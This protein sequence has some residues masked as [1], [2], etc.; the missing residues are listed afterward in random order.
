[1]PSLSMSLE[2]RSKFALMSSENLVG[3]KRSFG[4]IL[5]VI[6]CQHD[7]KKASRESHAKIK[8]MVI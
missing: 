6:L 5:A 8:P 2:L 1:M 3:G 7:A 4:A